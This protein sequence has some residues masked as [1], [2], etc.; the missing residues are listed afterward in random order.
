[1]VKRSSVIKIVA[2][3][4]LCS[5][6][7]FFAGYIVS[8]GTLV[9]WDNMMARP[10]SS[11]FR[12]QHAIFF[13][14]S[15][16]DIEN[17][18][19]FNRV[20][21]LLQNR[22]YKPV[23]ANDLFVG[24]IKGMAEAV[25]D[26]YTVYY[27]PEEMREFME[28]STGNY[29]GIGVLVSMDENYLLT[30]A[31]VFPDSPAREAGIRKGD[32]IV[33]VDNEDVTTIKDADLIVKKIKGTPGTVVTIT[34]F[35]EEIMDY[36]D[37]RVTR[38]TINVSYVSSEMLDDEIGYIRIKQFDNDVSQDFLKHLQ[39]LLAQGAKGVVI[40]LRDNPGG[41]YSE[42]VKICDTLLPSGLIVYVEDRYGNRREEV[43]DSNY[44]DIP[45]SVIVNGYS[46]SASEIMSAALKDYGRAVLVGTKTYGKGVV[47]QIDMGF[48]NGGGL[49]YTIARYFSPSGKSIQDMGVEPDIEVVL[50]EKLKNTSI[51]DIPH[52][53]DNQ[54]QVAIEEVRKQIR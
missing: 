38:R 54:L 21:D 48:A 42:V 39:N 40:D 10:F 34:V 14:E 52:E 41:D 33:K 15:E 17:I 28:A 45:M 47:Q 43:S 27:D 50:D 2:I 9:S 19:A 30:V 25:G 23:D 51:D 11:W 32:K 37:F 44:V 8:V 3:V 13:D 20:K 29:G 36:I 5:A 4:L 16:V 46:A 24:A 22:Y 7:S 49:K 12:Q 35:R 18:E 53:K 31:E 26:P 1:M 6:I